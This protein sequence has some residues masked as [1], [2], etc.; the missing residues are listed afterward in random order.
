MLYKKSED[1]AVMTL[2][3]YCQ[4]ESL[5][6]IKCENIYEKLYKQFKIS[7]IRLKLF[8]GQ[9]DVTICVKFCF[10]ICI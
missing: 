10:K 5:C 9:N 1:L 4:I 6:R 2:Q 3:S 8:C 7:K